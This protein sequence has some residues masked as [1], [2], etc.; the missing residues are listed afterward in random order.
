MKMK[1]AKA[2]L[3]GVVFVL[4]GIILGINALD[5]F[6]MNIFFDGWWTLLIIVPCFIGIFTDRDKTGSLI[7]MLFGTFLLLCSQKILSFDLVLKLLLPI[8]IVLIGLKMI[9]S[10]FKGGKSAKIM[11]D[12]VESGAKVHAVS[13]VFSTENIIYHG[14]EFASADLNAVF[15]KVTYDLRTA[16]IPKDCVIKTSAVFGTVNILLPANVNVKTNTTSIFGGVS[17]K[18]H[19]NSKANTVTVYVEGMTLFGGVDIK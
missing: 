2:I 6:P 8:I 9:F 19:E 17:D 1:R 14:E 10:S 12:V 13:A 4:L 5:L 15:G 11:K 16:Y 18:E 7:G 3:W